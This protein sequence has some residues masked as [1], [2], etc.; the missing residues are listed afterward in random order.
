[1]I[2]AYPQNK[3]ILSAEWAELSC[4]IVLSSA[5]ETVLWFID[6][7][8]LSS[9]KIPHLGFTIKSNIT[10]FA[11]LS[12]N[13]HVLSIQPNTQHNS[14][15]TVYCAVMSVCS[16]EAS[17]MGN[18][19]PSMC[20]SESAYIE[21][22]IILAILMHYVYINFHT[23]SWAVVVPR[24]TQVNNSESWDYPIA[25]TLSQSEMCLCYKVYVVN[26]QCMFF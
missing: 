3:T 13:R 2:V 9:P 23:L 4:D 19:V 12:T 21:G 15:T 16:R 14:T 6:D 17:V 7:F 24:T 26:Y 5:M 22:G 25:K 8:L 18:C 1:M 11:N 20:F 10:S